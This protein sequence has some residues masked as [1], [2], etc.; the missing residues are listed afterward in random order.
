L[1]SEEAFPGT[2]G[3]NL[4]NLFTSETDRTRLPANASSFRV[5]RLVFDHLCRQEGALRVSGYMVFGHSAGSQFVHRMI[6]LYPDPHLR[7]AIA[8]NAGWYTFPD[9]EVEWPYGF[10]GTG[11][12]EA[13]LPA[14]LAS[15]LIVLLGDQDINETQRSLRRTPEAMAQGKHR[16]ERGHAFFQAG[17]DQAA[18][19]GVP[20]RWRLEVVPGVGHDQTGMAPAAAALMVEA[21]RR[22][23]LTD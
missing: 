7:L 9:T 4:G 22:S 20:L 14:F 2:V 1:F 11:L 23:S 18:R 10:A 5:P 19:L 15:D 13:D 6:A 12:S 16:F 8:A 3:Y 21:M 17:R